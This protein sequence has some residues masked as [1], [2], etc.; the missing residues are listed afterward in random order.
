MRMP[1]AFFL[2]SMIAAAARRSSMRELVQ[3]P[4][5]TVSTRISFILVPGFRSMYSKARS[6]AAFSFGSKMSSGSGTLSKSETPCPGLVP[7]VTNGSKVSASR[8]TS[9]SNLAPS[10]VGRVFQYATASSQSFPVG[11]CGRPFRYAKVVSSGATM[12]ALAP[13][14]I[15]ILQMVMRASIDRDLMALPR[16]S[17]T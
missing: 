1:S 17:S 3:E 15:D 11:A 13:A 10:S 16:Y 7:Q 4:K 6:A 14:S 9:A 2:P 12:P 5:K 8:N